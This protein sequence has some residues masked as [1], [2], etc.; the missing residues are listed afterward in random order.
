MVQRTRAVPARH[1]ASLV[2]RGRLA[3]ASVYRAPTPGPSRSLGA[4]SSWRSCIEGWWEGIRGQCLLAA[5]L[6]AEPRIA[7]S[8]AVPV[9]PTRG[10]SQSLARPTKLV[11]VS[12][13]LGRV[14]PTLGRVS[15]DARTCQPRRS[16]VSAPTLGRVSPDART[17]QPRRSDM[18]APTLGHVSPDA[19]REYSPIAQRPDARSLYTCLPVPSRVR[20]SGCPP[21]REPRISPTGVRPH[22]KR[23]SFPGACPP[24][25]DARITLRRVSARTRSVDHRSPAHAAVTL[26]T[27]STVALN[28]S[29]PGV[30]PTTL[31]IHPRRR[32]AREA[33]I[34]TCFSARDASS[35]TRVTPPPCATPHRQRGVHI[36]RSTVRTPPR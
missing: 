23:A 33:C 20:P 22:A 1:R 19:R 26:D 25:L 21:A 13:T 29:G 11:H 17:C 6:T 16:D 4:R 36:S 34:P 3:P 30:L 27:A 8:P 2:L 12:P 7:A 28:P 32:S 35:Q 14:S 5:R 31:R 15:P 24:A 10:P 18:S 9:P